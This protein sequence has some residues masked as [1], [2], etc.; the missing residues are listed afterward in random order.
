MEYPSN[1][2]ETRFTLMDS[3]AN[4]APIKDFCIAPEDITSGEGGAK[5]IVTTSGQASGAS[6][7]VVRSG[8]GAEEMVVLEGM[9]E[10]VSV[11]PVQGLGGKTYV[12]ISHFDS[13]SDSRF[14]SGP[15]AGILVSTYDRSTLLQLSGT[16]K[17]SFHAQILDSSELVTD[18]PT[19]KAGNIA[20]GTMIQI[21]PSQVR[22]IASDTGKTVFVWSGLDS[23][24]QVV[25]ADYDSEHVVLALAKAQVV[26]LKVEKGSDSL[27]LALVK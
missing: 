22:L 27:G 14:S 25:M 10:V 20:E 13:E 16:E 3:W 11:W 18:H 9:D 19:L 15:E 12:V 23:G 1:G 26:V 5:Q 17:D 4:V 6:I 24:E 2:G 21:T 8:V 7:R